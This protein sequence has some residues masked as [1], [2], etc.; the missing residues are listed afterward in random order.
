V[1]D[2]TAGTWTG[3]LEIGSTDLVDYD[4]TERVQ[5]AMNADGHAVA[6]WE[7]IRGADDRRIAVNRY[8]G[9]NQTW[10]TA[11]AIDTSTDYLSWPHI[12]IDANG[13]LAAV[14]YATVPDPLSVDVNDRIKD[15]R[16]SYY[17]ATTTAWTTV[18]TFETSDEDLHDEPLVRFDGTGKAW[19]SWLQYNSPSLEA[20]IQARGY[21]PG[22][23]FEQATSVGS[24]SSLAL[25]VNNPG[26]VVTASLRTRFSQS[27]VGFF[28][29]TWAGVYTP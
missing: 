20:S 6:I 11:E 2:Y 19:V 17:N 15:G 14:W 23:G 25:A 26:Q 29:S 21:V 13:N 10:Q 7:E 9:V 22:T 16:Y 3:S 12:A 8:D 27:P 18:E 28:N 4:G 24:G 5:V 1:F